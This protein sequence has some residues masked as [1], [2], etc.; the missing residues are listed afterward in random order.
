[1][2]TNTPPQ[3]SLLAESLLLAGRHANH[4][5]NMPAIPIQSLLLPTLLLIVYY[6]LVGE[7]MVAISG[8]NNLQAMVPM[9][10]LAGG[11]FGALGAGFAVPFERAS[12][13]LS[14][15]WAFPIH[16]ASVIVGRLIA[17]AVRTLVAVALITAVGV[18]LGL[19]FA[20][21][22]LA[23]LPFLL[24]PVLVVVV[25]SLVILTFALNAGPNVNAVFTYLATGSVGMVFASSGVAPIGMYPPWLQPLIQYQP[26]SVAIDSMRAFVEGTSPVFPLLLTLAWFVTFAAV[27]GPLAIRR[28]RLA[29]E[30]G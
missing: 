26:M 9:C 16:R 3:T 11:M 4:W 17:E 30:S 10:A 7:S 23:V 25:F 6:L 1:M 19:R 5:R 18:A 12:G 22:W 2:T 8:T 27:F 15:W 14:R 29:A 28:Y 13:L 21:G 24:V 20:G